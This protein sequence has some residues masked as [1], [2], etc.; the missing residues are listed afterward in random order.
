MQNETRD[1]LSACVLS[2]CW[3][4]RHG[5]LRNYAIGWLS[6]VAK[7]EARMY[8]AST[9]FALLASILH[10]RRAID[11]LGPNFLDVKHARFKEMHAVIDAY[12]RELCEAG[13]GG[14]C[15]RTATVSK[16]DENLLWEGVLG[17]DTRESL[18]C[19]VFYYNGK[20]FCLHGEKEY[21]GLIEEKRW[22][23]AAGEQDHTYYGNS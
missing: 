6:L 14:E 1:I 15:K 11:P 4:S 10:H 2:I 20:S 18:L 16:E 23:V 3:I 5:T 19:V 17:V 12:F 22:S 21:R 9:V 8:P 13:V 7:L